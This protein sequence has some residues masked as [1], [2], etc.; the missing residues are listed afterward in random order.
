ME[1][2]K[3]TTLLLIISILALLAG[4]ATTS[5]YCPHEGS[6]ICTLSEKLNTSPES[7]SQVLQ[8][9]NVAAL[10][11]SLYTAQQADL[12]IDAIMA[13]LKKVKAEGVSISYVDALKY[14][15]DKFDLLSPSAQAAFI[16]MNPADL[17]TQEINIPLSEYDIDLLIKHLKKQKALVKVYL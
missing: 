1:T 9:A 12:F 6:A 5:N 4:C 14:V 3:L 2:L 15:S 7:I 11:K 10:E 17:A 8:I 16:I 13:D